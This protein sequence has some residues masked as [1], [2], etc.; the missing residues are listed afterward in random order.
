VPTD[1][2]VVDAYCTRVGRFLRKT[3]LDELPQLVNILI[4]D[5]SLIGYRPLVP[6]ETDCNKLRGRLGVFSARPGISG[7]AQICGR[8]DVTPK[9]KAYLDAY[10][11]SKA[12]ILFDLALALQ[13]VRV[14]VTRKGNRDND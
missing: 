9:N 3:S 1:R 14:V 13:T 4:G 2:A 10:A 12:S 5:M 7:L 11:V 8:D 6:A